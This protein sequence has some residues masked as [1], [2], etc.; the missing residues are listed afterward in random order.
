MLFLKEKGVD[1]V[2]YLAGGGCMHL[3][4][5][6]ATSGLNAFA[7][8]HEQAVAVA[9]EAYA[10][11]KN[12]PGAL[13]VTTGP[14]ATNAVTGVL[15]AY[16]DSTPCFVISGQ[17][18]T[19]DLKTRYGVRA[20]GSQEAD[21]I[22]IAQ[23]ITKYAVMVTDK[24]SIRYHLEY[25]WHMMT[26]GRKGPVWLDIPLDVQGSEVEASSL[27]G[28]LP[29]KS[30]SSFDVSSPIIAALNAAKRPLIIVGN[31]VSAYRREFLEL[32]ER[33][34]IPIAPT[35]KAMD[36][37]PNSHPLYAGRVGGMGDRHG[38][39]SMQNADLLLCLGSRLD[40]SVTGFDRTEWAPRA[41][42]IVVEIDPAEI[43]K[44]EGVSYM[45][46]IIADIGNV[47]S[48]LKLHRDGLVENSYKEWKAQI[49]QWKERYPVNSAE[50]Y[51][52]PEGGFTTYAFMDALC[53]H[54]PEGAYVA[55]CS[56]GTTAEIFFQAF[57]VKAGQTVRSNHGLGAMGFEIPN[58][59]GM[60]VA[61]GGQSVVCVAGD[62]G[63]QLNIQELA[64]ISGRKLPIK[65]FVINNRGYASI[66]NMQNGHFGG[67]HLGC[68]DASGMYLPEM[69]GV[70]AAYGIPYFRTDSLETLDETIKA[71]LS[72]HSAI[73]EIVVA[74]NCIVNPRTA[75]TLMPDGSMRSSLLENQHPPLPDDEAERNMLV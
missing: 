63:M 8:L 36:I 54:L 46:P 19:S 47:I 18:K 30:G 61:N 71:A 11:T 39:L 73:C 51:T 6:L 53:R 38:N 69:R 31:G 9:C 64:I 4:D 16:L 17:V 21:I 12:S 1:T 3:V 14:G 44:M 66:R 2:F 58:A 37:I 65:V 62:G 67:R 59:I 70:A 74:G 50:K 22:S 49:A 35:W 24:N 55:P 20:L 52:A 56:A 7:L 32:A 42:K 5:S 68:D 15:A 13:L 23:T 45:M 34:G 27:A 10:N 41:Q 48:E 57:T 26:S 29:H 75:T 72:E 28:F 40:F 43:A 60:C 33:L 25:A